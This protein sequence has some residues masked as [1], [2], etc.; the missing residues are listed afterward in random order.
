MYN[1]MWTAPKYF[2]H[3]I[4]TLFM[5]LQIFTFCSDIS[6]TLKFSSILVYFKNCSSHFQAKITNKQKKQNKGMQENGLKK[7][8]IGPEGTVVNYY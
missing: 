3:E 7:L 2:N 4:Y 8:I 6:N 1:N 5:Y